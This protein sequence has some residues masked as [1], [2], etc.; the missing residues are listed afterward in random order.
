MVGVGNFR[1]SQEIDGKKTTTLLKN[2]GY[3]P[4]YRMNLVFLGKAHCAGVKVMFKAG[5]RRMSASYKGF[6]VMICGSEATG[7]CEL[8][9][10][11]SVSREG[12]LVSFFTAGEDGAM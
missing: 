9:G 2:V 1:V 4:K 12:Q 11:V 10:I 3:A 7:I 6:S 8:T 5:G